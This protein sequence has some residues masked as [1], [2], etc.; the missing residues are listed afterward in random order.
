MRIIALRHGESEFNLLRLCNDDP[1]RAVD[2][3]AKGMDQAQQAALRLQ[4]QGI[5]TVYASPLLRT[6]RTAEIVTESLGL[7][8]VV[9]QRLGDIRS[10]CD[11][12]PVDDYLAAIAHDPIYARVNGGESLCD[13][14]HRVHGFLD[15]L[16]T[17]DHGLPLLVVHEET[18]RMI[19]AWCA[20]SGLEDVVGLPFPNAIPI[21][22]DNC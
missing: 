3:T 13:Y 21:T 20:G 8:V 14:A 7:N 19:Q 9:E 16:K 4:D 18:I 11:G 15:E 2:L 12:R 5:D 10:G 17:R 6:L 22:F 1:S